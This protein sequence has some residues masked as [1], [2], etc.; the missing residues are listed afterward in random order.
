MSISVYS[1][2]DFSKKE[3]SNNL[4]IG[5]IIDVS[6]EIEVITVFWPFNFKLWNI[7]FNAIFRFGK[8]AILSLFKPVIWESFDL[9]D[10]YN[11]WFDLKR[12]LP[13]DTHQHSDPPWQWQ[14]GQCVMC[15]QAVVSVPTQICPTLPT[16][17]GQETGPPLPD[18]WPRGVDHSCWQG[19]VILSS[20][21]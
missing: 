9:I 16:V 12:K 4:I 13:S 10:K 5:V 8:S 18:V 3:I 20:R 11:F 21:F 7:K 17:P 15:V 2:S 1:E 14:P 6:S 19:C